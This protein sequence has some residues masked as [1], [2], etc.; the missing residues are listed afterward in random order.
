MTSAERRKKFGQI[1]TPPTVAALMAD[2]VM[3]S[4]PLNVLDPAFGRGAL[5]AACQK[6]DGAAEFSAYEIDPRVVGEAPAELTNTT[7]VE[8][9]N[10]LAVSTSLKFGG[11]IANP[12]YIRHRELRGHLDLRADL[13]RAS[14]CEIPKSANQYVDFLVKATLHLSPGGRA[15]FL[16]PAE[17]MSANFAMGLKQYL[18][19]SNLI[20]SLVTF[21]NGSNVFDDALTTAS[22]VLL[23]K[24]KNRVTNITSYYLESMG[25][26]NVPQSIKQLQSVCSPRSVSTASLRDAAKWEPILRGDQLT[27]PPGWITLGE[28]VSTR[29]G[30]ATGANSFFL[31]SEKTRKNAKISSQHCLPCV[32]RSNDVQGLVFSMNDF[33]QLN[34]REEKVWLLDFSNNL[35]PDEQAYI[36]RGEEM[37]LHERYLTRTRRLWYGMEQ[38]DPAPIWAGVFG[39]GDLRFVFNESG[40][41]SLTNFH[42]VYPRIGGTRFSKALVAVLNS[43]PVRELMISHQRG[44][45]G[46]LMKFEPKDLLG[47]PIPDIRILPEKL[48]D[49]LAEQL[50]LMNARQCNGLDPDTETTARIVKSECL[51]VRQEEFRLVG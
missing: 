1:F 27:L 14:G 4:R 9:Q 36:T 3:E 42:S 45:G 7:T 16:I 40:A 39:R 15:A 48:I 28:I 44:Y 38:R 35:S 22:L 17:W 41:R 18:L 29:R 31:I 47:I 19:D 34:A 33:D 49:E 46:G 20:H 43:S 2:W 6:I 25:A 12:P 51:G 23:E 10:F 24:T 30:I 5:I 11:I 8:L 21:S 13:A 50:A 32:G 37:R 26:D